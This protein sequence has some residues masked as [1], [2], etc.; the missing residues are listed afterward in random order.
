MVGMGEL[1]RGPATV[2]E[3]FLNRRLV[4]ACR[5][6]T[7]PNRFFVHSGTLLGHVDMPEGTF[8]PH[9]HLYNQRTLYD[10]LDAA[11]VDW[12]IYHGDFPQSLFL[13]HQWDKLDHYR[14]FDRWTADVQASDLPSYVFI[15]P[16]YFGKE[17][18][19][20]HPPQD[21]MRGDLMVAEC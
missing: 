3:G 16:Y 20:Q 1:G 17:E 18:N 15:E 6:P 13:T 21:I 19:G 12:R 2:S 8:N 5:T 9:L 7:W 11:H 14:K 10:E 4:V